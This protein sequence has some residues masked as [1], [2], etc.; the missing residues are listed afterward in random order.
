MKRIF[1]ILFAIVFLLLGLPL[2]IV[3][4]LLI[5]LDSPG[6]VL[7]RSQRIGK[8]G[9]IFSMYVFRTMFN[10]AADS[11]GGI[12]KMGRFLRNN[13][14]DHLPTL[15]N[16]IKGDMS[17]VGP[18]PEMVDKAD[19]NK[20]DLKPILC[21]KPG[22]FSLAIFALREKYNSTSINMRNEYEKHYIKKNSLLFDLWLFIRF[23]F[24]A[25][26]KRNI[27]GKV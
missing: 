24:V 25:I 3:I 13:S 7:Y 18:R 20:D 27:K 1:D 11:H 6:T 15:L 26:R 9:K 22:M 16:V 8:D 12:T 14:L 2:F 21:V 5:K 17:I 19:L 23:I 10:N 4:A